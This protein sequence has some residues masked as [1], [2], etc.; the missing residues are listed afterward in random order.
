MMKFKE[1]ETISEYYCTTD[2]GV[3][4]RCNYNGTYWE[5]LYGESW[6]VVHGREEVSCHIAWEEGTRK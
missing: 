5:R 6:E 3:Y 4:Y 1:I 2:D